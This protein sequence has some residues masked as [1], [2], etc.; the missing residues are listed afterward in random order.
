MA[1]DF[2]QNKTEA[3][4]VLKEKKFLSDIVN[5]YKNLKKD[6]FEL[7]EFIK[8]GQKENDVEILKDCSLST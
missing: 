6:F 7:D 1:E 8:L 4:K 5:N 2:W 3:Q